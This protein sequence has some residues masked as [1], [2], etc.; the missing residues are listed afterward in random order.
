MFKG[1]KFTELNRFTNF[2]LISSLM[3]PRNAE[4]LIAFF[5]FTFKIEIIMR[6]EKLQSSRV[7]HFIV[8]I[9][10]SSCFFYPSSEHDDTLEHN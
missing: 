1:R 2:V 5:L 9:I 3:S 10:V 7:P 6:A 4:F 8:I